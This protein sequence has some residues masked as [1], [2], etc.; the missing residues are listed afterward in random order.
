MKGDNH[1]KI[2]TFMI[3]NA[4]PAVIIGVLLVIIPRTL[5]SLFGLTPGPGVDIDGQL[6]GSELI[7]MGLICWFARN[8]SEP[9]YQRGIL[10]AFVIANLISMVLA[11]ISIANN[12]FNGLGWIAAVAYGILFVVYGYYLVRLPRV[13]R[14]VQSQNQSQDSHLPS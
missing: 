4:I 14:Q 13:M 1:M 8:I 9:R 3:L 6:Y 5:V 10:T 12:T 11:L 2:K 7:L